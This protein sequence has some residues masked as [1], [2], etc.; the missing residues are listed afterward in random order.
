MPD[1][2]ARTPAEGPGRRVQP[3]RPVPPPGPQAATRGELAEA[4]A[5][6]RRPVELPPEPSAPRRRLPAPRRRKPR[7]ARPLGPA[8]RRRRRAA[9]APRPDAGGSARPARALL[10][11]VGAARRLWPKRLDLAQAEALLTARARGWAAAAPLFARIGDSGGPVL[12]GQT[13][14][15][16]LGP[17]GPATAAGRWRSPPPGARDRSPRRA[18][19]TSSSSPPSSAG[20]GRSLPVFGAPEGLRLVCFTD[21][22]LAAAPGWQGLPPPALPAEAAA[23]A[24][25]GFGGDASAGFG[26]DASAGFGGDASVDPEA[27]AAWLKIRTP[28]ALSLA[29]I[30]AEASLWVDPDC[31]LLGNLDTLFTRWLLGQELVLWRHPASD[32]RDMAE[33]H[34]LAGALPARGVL[35]QAGRLAM[36][37]IPGGRGACDT[38]MVWRRH[39]APG[40]ARTHRG[41]VAG[42]GRRPGPGRP[43]A[44]PR[45]QRPGRAARPAGAGRAAGHPARPPRRRRRQHLHRPHRAPAARGRG[46][47]AAARPRRPRY[48]LAGSPAASSPSSFSPRRRTPIPPRRCCAATSSPASWPGPSPSATP[49]AS[50]RTPAR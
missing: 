15:G 5:E 34:L 39:A 35:A 22:P 24:G 21:Q 13:A 23:D 8:R 50:P 33:R 3:G 20:R 10:R 1:D 17:G 38:G 48:P 49:S 14:A 37:K 40:L 11:P 41:L 9:R 31:W 2:G 18:P 16:L 30:D 28:E 27:W 46:P 26:G 43:R 44:L 7:H 32:W 6:A 42:V 25:G 29:G 47:P 45:A 36:D 19:A 12:A 4:P